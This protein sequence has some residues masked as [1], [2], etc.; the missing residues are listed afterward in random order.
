MRPPSPN[1]ADTSAPVSTRQPAGKVASKGVIH[2]KQAQ[3]RISR[4]MKAVAAIA[5]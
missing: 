4:L 5:K 3:R 1:P 2:K